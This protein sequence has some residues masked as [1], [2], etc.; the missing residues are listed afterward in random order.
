MK[1]LKQW[2]Q[3]WNECDTAGEF[4]TGILLW[5]AFIVAGTLT[6]VWNWVS[7]IFCSRDDK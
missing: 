4:F 5:L 6:A 2:Q 7:K 1:W 3:A